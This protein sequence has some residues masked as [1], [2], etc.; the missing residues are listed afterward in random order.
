MSLKHP[1]FANEKTCKWC[2]C[3]F[4]PDE[5]SSD[6][7]CSECTRL[8]Y[9]LPEDKKKP[10]EEKEYFVKDGKPATDKVKFCRKCGK[11]FSPKHPATKYCDE[12]RSKK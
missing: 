11:E 9:K 12:C 5:S 4:L 2:G 10:P 6:D 7:Y 3:T 8:G 1:K